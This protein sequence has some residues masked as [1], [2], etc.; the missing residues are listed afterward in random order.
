MDE[1]SNRDFITFVCDCGQKIKVP[2]KH[3]GV[4]GRCK[5]CGR[6]LIVPTPEPPTRRLEEPPKPE[7]LV[8]PHHMRELEGDYSEEDLITYP[9]EPPVRTE[10]V[11]PAVKVEE[12]KDLLETLREIFRYPFVDKLSA[13]IFFS[14]AFFFS[15][16]VWAIVKFTGYVIRAIVPVPLLNRAVALIVQ[17]PLIIVII[18]IRLMYF[19]Y[20]LLIIEKSA[21]GSK[22]IPE[23][24]VF[25]SWGENLRD[26]MKVLAVSV[27]AFSPFLIYAFIVNIDAIINMLQPYGRGR[28]AGI[29]MLG[30]L[31]SNLAMLML[32]YAVAAFYMPMVMMALVVTKSFAKA[33]NPVFIFR[34][35]A[36]IRKE[37]LIAMLIIFIF[38][39]GSLTLFTILKDLLF[40]DWFSALS[41]YVAEPIIKFYVFV[42]TMHIIGLLYYRNG[43]K[44]KW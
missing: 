15:P 6:K 25:Q 22:R 40:T 9:D 19:S 14:G 27:V 7:H 38:L 21:E 39:R 20:L 36:R 12:E 4:K 5:S 18:S 35:I 44:L 11:M 33:V 29:N 10:S 37:Y 2:A 16:L 41:N 8:S 3:A 24:P 43:E 34:S 26:L 13:Q 30:G 1:E 17:I 42:V 28:T 32:V 23:L 31:S